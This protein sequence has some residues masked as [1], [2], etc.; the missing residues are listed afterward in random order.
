MTESSLEEF[1][2]E[3]AKVKVPEKVFIKHQIFE[4]L[5]DIFGDDVEIL[6]NY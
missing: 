4:D 6:V 3:I 2:K 1:E 5:K